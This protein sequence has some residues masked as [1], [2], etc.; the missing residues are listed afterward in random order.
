MKKD[1][2][3]PMNKNTN[4]QALVDEII[5]GRRLVR[6]EDLSFFK[7]CDLD[8]L[9]AGA[10]RLREHFVGDK[11]D[12]CTIIA[13]KSGN[14]G[15]NCRFCAQSAH[16]H[17]GC[18]VYPLLNYD[19]I[20]A[21]AK[22]NQEEGVDR[23][24]IVISGHGP[25]D[26]DFEKIVGIYERLHGELKISLCASLGFLTKEQFERLYAAGVRNYHNNI[27]TSRSFFSSICTSHSFDD[28]VA[29]IK[30]AKEAGLHV[31]SGGIIG[32]GESMD[33][34]IEMALELAELE[35]GS[36]PINTL[37]PIPGT[38]LEDLP[39]LS[40]KEILRTVAMFRFVNPTAQI[41]I[42]AGRKLLSDN[43]KRLFEGGASATITGNMLTTTA[44]TIE[45]DREMLASLGRETIPKIS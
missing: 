38:P 31:C 19:E 32:M 20:Y 43:G 10:D 22:D 14:C 24:A 15:E 25:S 29:N 37:L 8:E 27:E 26:E 2:N 35:I 41:R 12:L 28:K 5:N 16:N 23:F 30:R 9:L 6:S 21:E 4:I 18:E 36:I 44:S 34:R 40:E 39:V 17:T 11:V 3:K 13:G 45:T 1:M 33:D 7:M 42:A